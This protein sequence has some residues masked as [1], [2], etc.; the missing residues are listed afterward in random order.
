MET[1]SKPLH[2]L[3]LLPRPSYLVITAFQGFGCGRPFTTQDIFSSPSRRFAFSLSNS[4]IRRISGTRK[5]FSRFLVLLSRILRIFWISS[6]NFRLFFA[7]FARIIS[8]NRQKTSF[9]SL[10]SEFILAISRLYCKI[11][12]FSS[13]R[14][15]KSRIKCWNS[16]EIA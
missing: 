1:A 10:I 2:P 6:L 3:S 14:E 9:L 7:I 15:E 12:R 11:L 5:F 13:S 4:S 8:F 16:L